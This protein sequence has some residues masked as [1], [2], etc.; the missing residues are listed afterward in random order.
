M[1][2]DMKTGQNHLNATEAAA[3]LGLK[4]SYLYRLTSTKQIPFIKYGGRLILF[5]R[6]ALETWKQA[7]MQSVPTAAETDSAAA[8]YCAANPR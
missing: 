8:M 7:R 3:F 5:E 6:T 2:N 1:A 4:K